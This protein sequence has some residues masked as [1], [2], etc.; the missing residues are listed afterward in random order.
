MVRENMIWL[1]AGLATLM[2]GVSV[3]YAVDKDDR[4]CISGT[5]GFCIGHGTE[6]CVKI[7]DGKPCWNCVGNLPLA[8]TYCVWL[9]GEDCNGANPTK[10]DCGPR[11]IGTCGGG[12]CRSQGIQGTCQ[13]YEGCTLP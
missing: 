6:Q 12:V 5:V 7:G 3:A 10:V 1:A 8:N 4:I 11:G 2:V 13:I 9:E